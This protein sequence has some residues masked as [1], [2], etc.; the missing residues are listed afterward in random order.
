MIFR[1]FAFLV[2]G[3]GAL[4]R[5]DGLSTTQVAASEATKIEAP[6]KTRVSSQVWKKLFK[7]R[8]QEVLKMF[9]DLQLKDDLD[10][11]KLTASIVPANVPLADYD[12]DLSLKTDNLGFSGKD[13]VLK[14]EGELNGQKFTYEAPIGMVKV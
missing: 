14:G 12:F 1:T 6:F 11:S 13:L 10:L 4:T 5:F 3:L 9:K 8:D 2:F 7:A